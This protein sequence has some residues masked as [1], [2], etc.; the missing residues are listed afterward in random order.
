VNDQ[1]P[2]PAPGGHFPGCHPEDAQGTRELPEGEQ[3]KDTEPCWHCG[4]ATTRGACRCA[5]CLYDD[6][7]PQQ[8][9]YHC[10]VCKRWWAWMTGL[11]VTAITFGEE[12]G[13]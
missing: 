13:A 11:S 8:A 3:I 4:T 12:A 7:I 9:V 6:Y 2:R 1:A 10:P 5:G